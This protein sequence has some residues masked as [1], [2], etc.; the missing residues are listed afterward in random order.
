MGFLIVANWKMNG[1]AKIARQYKKT[2]EAYLESHPGEVVVC[3]PLT[4][5]E[6]LKSSFYKL[7]AQD[8][9][10]FAG[11]GAHT[12]EV[13]ASMLVDSGCQYVIVGH[14]ERKAID[15][16]GAIRAKIRTAQ[17]QG[18]KII[19]CIGE[20]EE[21]RLRGQHL[22]AI[23]TQFNGLSEVDFNSVL[24]AYEPLWAIGTGKVINGEQL[25][26]VADFI[27]D[28]YLSSGQAKGNDCG[29]LYGGSVSRESAIDLSHLKQIKGLL[30]G[31][32]SL[33]CNRLIDILKAIC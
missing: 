16:Q 14:S 20:S 5:L 9:S 8:V 4:Y 30:I 12:G 11:F 23:E 31:A 3:P 32:S 28:R 33:E 22:E 6:L 19:L 2:L 25:I 17:E 7:G 18:L 21:D 26:E 13:S 24:V 27:I 10:R 29:I 15:E 1:T